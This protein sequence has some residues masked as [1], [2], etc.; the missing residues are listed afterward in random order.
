MGE[1]SCRPRSCSC[2]PE[3]DEDL[4]LGEGSPAWEPLSLI[5][6]FLAVCCFFGMTIIAIPW[7]GVSAIFATGIASIVCGVIARQRITAN[8]KLGR[9]TALGG[10][11]SASITMG[12]VAAIILV[13]LTGIV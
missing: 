1:C 4:Y 8:A 6:L 5:S 13:V 3:E 7:I 2:H 11:I 10:I 9:G 12:I